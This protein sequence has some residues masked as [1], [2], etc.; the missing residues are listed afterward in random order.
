MC[1]VLS[2]F[3]APSLTVNEVKYE[4]VISFVGLL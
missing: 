1:G 3:R 2:K 4:V